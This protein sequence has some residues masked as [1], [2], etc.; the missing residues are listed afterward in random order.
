[1]VF[2]LTL[3]V[4]LIVVQARPTWNELH[5]YSFDLFLRDFKIEYKASEIELRKSLFHAELG[6][7]QKTTIYFILYFYSYFKLYVARVRAHNSRTDAS[8]KEGINKF[9]A[10][11]V[12][13]KKAY[14]GRSKGHSKA[15]KNQLKHMKSLPENFAFKV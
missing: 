3:I 13:E 8:W 14:T 12:N 11:T 10:M 1:M 2:F 5:N 9:S 15:Q 4:S 6:I 7:F